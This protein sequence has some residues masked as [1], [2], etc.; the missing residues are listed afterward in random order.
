MNEQFRCCRKCGEVKTLEEFR[1]YGKNNQRRSEC[2]RCTCGRQAIFGTSHQ[3]K[4]GTRYG[5]LQF[6]YL[7]R[8]GP[9]CWCCRQSTKN[10]RMLCL[11]CLAGAA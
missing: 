11:K 6:D 8:S 5:P 9:P 2:R 7:Y 1:V 3:A 4:A 10:G